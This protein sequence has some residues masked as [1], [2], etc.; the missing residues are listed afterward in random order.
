MIRS[1]LLLYSVDHGL[2]RVQ[3]TWAHQRPQKYKSLNL[4][5]GSL[6][7]QNQSSQ[8]PGHQAWSH[9]HHK[10]GEVRSGLY[11]MFVLLRRQDLKT[12]KYDKKN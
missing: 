7:M 1:A 3:P 6:A 2:S 8:M 10:V 5:I 9:N 4:H 12:K 11:D